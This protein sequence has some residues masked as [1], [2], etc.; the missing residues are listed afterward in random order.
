M[1][2]FITL[3]FLMVFCT[4][5]GIAQ[6]QK[7]FIKSIPLEGSQTVSLATAGNIEVTEWDKDYIRITTTVEV[8]NFSE[9][10]LKRLVA[11]G[12]YSIETEN[13][14]GVLVVNMPKVT[15]QVTIKGSQ[16]KEVFNYQIEVPKNVTVET[17]KD[18][19]TTAEIN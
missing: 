5:I 14:D 11:V 12:R 19:T 9:D 15:T 16:L 4:A 18:V 3:L 13:K 8:L 2:Q 17:A 7:T 10:I 1:K 6:S